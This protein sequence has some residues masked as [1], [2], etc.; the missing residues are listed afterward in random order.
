[1][2]PG[3][4]IP[5]E[6]L[7]DA[8]WSRIENAVFDELAA[9]LPAERP[10]VRERRR[11]WPAI[12]IGGLVVVQAAAAWFV[13]TKTDSSE[14]EALDTARIVAGR[15]A[16]E[17]LLGDVAIGLEPESALVVVKNAV[18]GSLVVLERGTA[19]FS[20]PPRDKRPA[21]VVQAGDVRVE[22][23]GTRFRVE[24][25]GGSARV[26]AYEGKVRVIARGQSDLLRHGEHWP[27]GVSQPSA[28]DA[29]KT[30]PAPEPE[31]T[32]ARDDQPAAPRIVEPGRRARAGSADSP[33]SRRQRDRFDRA[34]LLEASDPEQALRIYR[35]IA[36]DGGRWGENALYAAGRLETERGRRASALRLLST[37]LA[38]HPHGANAPDARALLERLKPEDKA[39]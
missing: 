28:A 38:R 20:V 1:M 3:D 33:T 15:E 31:A 13:F 17:T 30:T 34:A 19:S 35:G 2:K 24:R 6:P 10:T 26:D 5:I 16:T 12:A 32:A 7:S 27:R 36:A 21:F 39:Q 25:V 8:T 18:A 37:Y 29:A 14:R 23:V 9:P 11:R 4:D 22:V